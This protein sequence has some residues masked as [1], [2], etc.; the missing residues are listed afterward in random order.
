MQEF[1]DFLLFFGKASRF[2]FGVSVF[3]KRE[4]HHANGF[5]FFHNVFQARFFLCLFFFPE[6][7]KNMLF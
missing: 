7:G 2:C 6:I 5:Q 3:S 4:G 1:E